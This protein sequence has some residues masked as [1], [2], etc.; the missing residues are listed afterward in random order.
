MFENVTES[1]DP[2]ARRWT[3]PGNEGETGREPQVGEG[4]DEHGRGR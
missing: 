2:E 1:R 4:T 3:A